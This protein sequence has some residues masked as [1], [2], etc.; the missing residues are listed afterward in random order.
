MKSTLLTT[1]YI[2]VALFLTSCENSYKRASYSNSPQPSSNS[3][4]G[5]LIGLSKDAYQVAEANMITSLFRD[6]ACCI[7]KFRT[8][9][10]PVASS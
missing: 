9:H 6:T 2:I 1:I 10:S 3:G 7:K 8:L 5:N 4:Q